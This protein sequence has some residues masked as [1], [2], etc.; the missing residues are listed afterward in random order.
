VTN[1]FAAPQASSDGSQ[2][3][4][5]DT[6]HGRLSRAIKL[7]KWMD[8]WLSCA[9]LFMLTLL[10]CYSWSVPLGAFLPISATIG[11]GVT[12]VAYMAWGAANTE[13]TQSFCRVYAA[14]GLSALQIR[15]LYY[16]RYP[17]HIF[18]HTYKQWS[19]KYAENEWRA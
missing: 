5:A 17:L 12:W 11:G 18:L 6:I 13:L 16:Q 3:K 19:R 8:F 10:A 2:D 14:D 9:A 1:E 4:S 7:Q 15:E